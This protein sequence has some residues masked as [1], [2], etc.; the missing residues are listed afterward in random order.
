MSEALLDSPEIP[1]AV[2]NADVLT[3]LLARIA[4]Q[5]HRAFEEFVAQTSR[6][7]R[8]LVAAVVVSPDLSEDACQEVYLQVWQTAARFDPLSGTATGWLIILARRRAIDKVRAEQAYR[9]RQD[10]YSALSGTPAYDEVAER[11]AATVDAAA[12]AESLPVLTPKQRQAITLAF[13]AGMTYA[14]VALTLDIPLPTVKSRIR[15]GVLKLR[16]TLSE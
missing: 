3:A 2:R 6:Y 9:N 1:A 13:Y 11:V 8:A 4:Q 16:H 14:E 7:V 12:V 10:R 15:D 5:D